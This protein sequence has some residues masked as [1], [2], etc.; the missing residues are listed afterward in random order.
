MSH[1]TRARHPVEV[2]VSVK[3]GKSRQRRVYY[4][5]R[6]RHGEVVHLSGRRRRLRSVASISRT[7]AVAGEAL[8]K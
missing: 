6:G 7:P 8:R 1:Q 2:C 4:R 5:A 3:G